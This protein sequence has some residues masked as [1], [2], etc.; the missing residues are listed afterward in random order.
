[1][2]TYTHAQ[3]GPEVN[4]E[5]CSLGTIRLAF[6]DGTGSLTDLELP[7]R[8]PGQETP[9]NTSVST[10]SVPGGRLHAATAGFLHGCHRSYSGVLVCAGSTLPAE[11]PSQ[12]KLGVS[13]LSVLGDGALT[14]DVS[15]VPSLELVCP[16]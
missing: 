12:A 5:G 2:R 14:Q 4:L 3:W 8:L 1:M 15:L 7:N 16:S 13:S 9:G 6:F 10:S 11:P